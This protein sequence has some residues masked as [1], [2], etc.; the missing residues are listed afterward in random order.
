MLKT[1]RPDSLKEKNYF[2][3]NGFY[4]PPLPA[5]TAR[6]HGRFFLS[7]TSRTGQ[8]HAENE[9]CGEADAARRVLAEEEERVRRR[10]GKIPVVPRVRRR[11]LHGRRLQD[12]RL[13]FVQA[14]CRG[15]RDGDGRRTDADRAAEKSVEEKEEEEEDDDGLE[16]LA[17]AEGRIADSGR[18]CN[19]V[20]K[21]RQGRNQRENQQEKPRRRRRFREERGRRRIDGNDA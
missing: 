10:R 3:G 4:P 18:R 1:A 19:A 17:A 16:R 11:V 21:R 2:T 5:D 7:Q 8:G 20:K 12:G 9:T 14:H 6:R 15:A 13:R